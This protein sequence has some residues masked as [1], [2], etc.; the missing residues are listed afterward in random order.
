MKMPKIIVELK[1]LSMILGNSLNCLWTTNIGN[2]FF[3]FY[4]LTAKQLLKRF[5]Y[6]SLVLFM[7]TVF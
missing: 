5:E 3:A 7:R 6:L 4:L 2:P 1:C